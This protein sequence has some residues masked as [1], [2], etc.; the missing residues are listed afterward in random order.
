MGIG[1]K[2]RTPSQG[3]FNQE[4]KKKREDTPQKRRNTTQPQQ[5]KSQ[6]QLQSR[7]QKRSSS[8]TSKAN[9]NTARS[10]SGGRSSNTTRDAQWHSVNNS[11]RNSVNNSQRINSQYNNSPYE[12]EEDFTSQN[13]NKKSPKKAILIFAA[14]A[15][16][17]VVF[18]GFYLF[19]QGT[20]KKGED[21]PTPTKKVL[22]APEEED[23]EESP[24]EGT[25][26]DE[27]FQTGDSNSE[28]GKYE[29]GTLTKTTPE[30]YSSSD[31]LKD[32]NGYEI[33]AVYTVQNITYDV[34]HVNYQAKRATIDDGMEFYWL[35]ISYNGKKYRAQCSYNMFRN[36]ESEGICKVAVE[37]LT[38]DSGQQVISYM[39]VVSEDYTIDDAEND[40][41]F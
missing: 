30:H 13:N 25:T 37:I 10:R 11:Q 40:F 22:T 2:T 24:E 16:I 3:T 1:M 36:L 38:L 26:T 9:S 20:S 8:T 6:S 5:Q 19:S 34:A 4:P 27:G 39:K 15:L 35:E 18:G 28:G 21:N 14:I 12:E 17:T 32:L 41:N 29:E 7:P 31:F 23:T 33:P